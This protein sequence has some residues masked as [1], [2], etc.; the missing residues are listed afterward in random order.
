M[1]WESRWTIICTQKTTSNQR[2][3]PKKKKKW[4]PVYKW[5]ARRSFLK[6]FSLEGVFHYSSGFRDLRICFCMWTKKPRHIEKVGK[7]SVS[8]LKRE[9]SLEIS[10]DPFNRPFPFV[11]E[12]KAKCRTGLISPACQEDLWNT[13]PIRCSAGSW[14]G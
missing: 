11:S 1:Y 2:D 4:F 8:Q 3:K 6:V 5:T 10:G 7:T 14:D 9:D 13:F 12:S